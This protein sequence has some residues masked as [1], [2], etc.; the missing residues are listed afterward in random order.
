MKTLLVSSLLLVMLVGSA[1]AQTYSVPLTPRQRTRERPAPP[2]SRE[3]V[4]GGIPRAARGGNA[5]QMINPA[6]P[7]QY[8]GTPD[9]TVVPAPYN[10]TNN[11]PTTEQPRYT[12]VILFGFRW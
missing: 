8:Y 9:E 12:G 11:R 2:I 7:A 1:A 4:V 3:P 5:L 10:H 6:A